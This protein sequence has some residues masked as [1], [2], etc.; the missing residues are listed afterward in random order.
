M[1]KNCIIQQTAVYKNCIMY[2]NCDTPLNKYSVYINTMKLNTDF[3]FV[4]TD[5]VYNK[6]KFL[7]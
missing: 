3:V 6:H 5:F 4:K 2:K 7:V 1:Y